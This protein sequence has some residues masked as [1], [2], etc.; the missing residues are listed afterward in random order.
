MRKPLLLALLLASC[1]QGPK[2]FVIKEFD[3]PDPRSGAKTTPELQVYVDRFEQDFDVVVGD[4]PVS[5]VD[6]FEDNPGVAGI[7]YHWTKGNK[8]YREIKIKRSYYDMV[9]H[10]DLKVEQLIY[11][12]LGH[13]RFDRK[14][15]NER[16]DDGSPASIMRWHLF[17][18]YEIFKFYDPDRDYYLDELQYP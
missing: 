7:C 6:E 16:R 8:S 18:S 2:D 3:G 15:N 1:R 5:F 4:I 11:H 9:K 10:Y 14:H 13:C 12:E 17:N